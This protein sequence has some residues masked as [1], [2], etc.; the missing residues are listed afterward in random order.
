[1]PWSSQATR[2]GGHG[3]DRVGA[4][5]LTLP[6]VDESR[7]LGQAWVLVSTATRPCLSVPFSMWE[8][9]LSP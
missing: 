8:P 1:M 4:L 6:K 7:R 5:P 9:S 3:E 2:A